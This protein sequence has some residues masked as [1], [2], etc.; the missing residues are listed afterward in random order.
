MDV[1]ENIRFEGTGLIRKQINKKRKKE[2][3]EEN[4]YSYVWWLL[5]DRFKMRATSLK[6][7]SS[8][9]LDFRNM[10]RIKN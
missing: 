2:N 6:T 7:I 5:M 1:N 9:K 10:K 4:N 8:S 3:V